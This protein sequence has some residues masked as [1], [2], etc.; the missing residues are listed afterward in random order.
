MILD[1]PA[2]YFSEAQWAYQNLRRKRLKISR[3]LELN[4]PFELFAVNRKRQR[5]TGYF[6]VDIK[7]C[8]RT[9]RSV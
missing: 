9:R 3:F 4:D 5:N 1:V 6:R 7:D 2:Y 8:A